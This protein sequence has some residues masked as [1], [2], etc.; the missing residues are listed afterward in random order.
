MKVKS[1]VDLH[2]PMQRGDG[3]GERVSVWVWAWVFPR[4]SCQTRKHGNTLILELG[5]GPKRGGGRVGSRELAGNRCCVGNTTEHTA[6]SLSLRA[7]QN[8]LRSLVGHANERLQWHELGGGKSLSSK[9][10]GAVSFMA[11]TCA[12]NYLNGYLCCFEGS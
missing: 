1:D 6:R 5:V 3:Y 12:E 8:N 9:R 11:F 7:L 2:I 10:S 4:S